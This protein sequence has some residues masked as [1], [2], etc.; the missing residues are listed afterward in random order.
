MAIEERITQHEDMHFNLD[1]QF[2]GMEITVKSGPVKHF[3]VDQFLDE[4]ETYVVTP[5]QNHRVNV[6]GYLVEDTNE[7]DPTKRLRVFVDECVLDGVDDV[8]TFERASP[9]K[10]VAHLFW[11]DLPAGAA[12]ITDTPTIYVCRMIP[13]TKELIEQLDRERPEMFDTTGMAPVKEG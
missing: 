9:L 7:P 6:N 11:F 3:G 1:I 5:N 13:V 10:L 4:D 12:Q 8:Y 2:Q